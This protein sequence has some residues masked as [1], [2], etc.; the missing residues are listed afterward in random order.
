[1]CAILFACTNAKN[2]KTPPFSNIK[3]YSVSG[4]ISLPYAEISGILL[5]KLFN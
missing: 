3:T 1:M 5:I 4:I 2:I